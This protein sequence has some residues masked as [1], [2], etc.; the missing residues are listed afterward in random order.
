MEKRDTIKAR[1]ALVLLFVG[2]AVYGYLKSKQSMVAYGILIGGLLASAI[3]FWFSPQRIQFLTYV[4]EV[5]VEGK[6]VV[7]PTAKE[8]VQ[9]TVV[10]FIFVFILAVFLWGVDLLLTKILY[11]WF[12]GRG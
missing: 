1:L 11:G 5:V 2:V 6:K 7:W 4:N 3:L 12:L 10:V 8:T 9:R